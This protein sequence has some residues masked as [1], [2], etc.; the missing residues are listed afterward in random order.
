MNKYSIVLMLLFFTLL[1]CD[2]PPPPPTNLPT[3]PAV[4]EITPAPTL[5]IDATATIFANQL[6]PTPIPEGVYIV[7]PG[8]TLSSLADY[9]DTTIDDI[10]QTN[11]ITDADKLEVGQVLVI[12][13][14]IPT[15][16]AGG[17]AEE[18]SP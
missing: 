14:L 13:S 5:D 15:P 17:G 3:S 8:D 4:I 6:R 18:I 1:A 2:P 7:Q 11:E 12:P 10:L 16:T 9:F